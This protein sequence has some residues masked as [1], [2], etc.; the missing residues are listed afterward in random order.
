[1]ASFAD[2]MNNLNTGLGNVSTTPIGQLGMQMLANSGWT[3]DNQGL[4]QRLGQSFQGMQQVQ[5][6]QQQTQSTAQLR[7]L[8][9]MELAQRMM[10]QQRQAKVEQAQREYLQTHSDQFPQGSAAGLAAG[11]GI[12]NL[13]PYIKVDQAGMPNKPF[14]FDKVNPDNTVTQMVWDPSQKSY[15]AGATTKPVPQQQVDATV[16][17]N[18]FNQGYKMNV[19]APVKQQTAD[20]ATTNAQSAQLRNSTLAQQADLQNL[21]FLQ[22][23]NIAKSTLEN[24][25]NGVRSQMSKQLENVDAVLNDPALDRVFGWTGT[26][27]TAPGSDAAR[28][29]SMLDKIKA[30]A[31]MAGLVQ[32]EQLGIKLNPVSDNDF[33]NATNS[34]ISINNR[35]SAND[36]RKVLQAYKKSLE[37]TVQDAGDRYNNMAKAYEQTPAYG[38]N[39]SQGG[40]P[41]APQG[42]TP[43]RSGV[44]QSGRRVIQ[45]S[46]GSMEYAN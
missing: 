30:N 11:A 2:I 4:G 41:A 10:D 18:A 46:D 27:P 42:K 21:K 15:V 45:Y 25:Y 5:Q 9:G 7:Q 3:P 23:N 14:T 20:A 12:T 13:A 17:N 32:L 28:V 22:S 1:M 31:G 40:Q 26:A 6:Q 16:Q 38:A 29:E 36:A 34:A 35:Q 43:V 19:E 44:D 8:Q 37:T 39:R 33:R 24:G